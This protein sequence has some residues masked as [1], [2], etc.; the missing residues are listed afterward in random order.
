MLGIPILAAVLQTILFAGSIYV[1]VH[2]WVMPSGNFISSSSGQAKLNAK[3][4]NVLVSLVG[5]AISA[6]AGLALAI[7]AKCFIARSLASNGISLEAYETLRKIGESRLPSRASVYALAPVVLFL[8]SNSAAPAVISIWQA[9]SSHVDLTIETN[10]TSFAAMYDYRNATTEQ[11]S[12][13]EYDSLV[14]RFTDGIGAMLS[15]GGYSVGD[16]DVD[17]TS[18]YYLMEG[19]SAV[20]KSESTTVT[21]TVPFVVAQSNC[22]APTSLL[23]TNLTSTVDDVR[24][25][26]EDRLHC[27]GSAWD[28]VYSK[29]GIVSNMVHCYQNGTSYAGYFFINATSPTPTF[30]PIASCITTVA[31]GTKSGVSYSDNDPGWSLEESSVFHTHSPS[32]ADLIKELKYPA[33]ATELSHNLAA[34]QWSDQSLGG[35]G[36]VTLNKLVGGLVDQHFFEE[37]RNAS[38]DAKMSTVFASLTRA[39]AAMAVSKQV[40]AETWATL[41]ASEDVNSISLAG[42]APSSPPS[43]I[44]TPAFMTCSCLKVG[45]TGWGLLYLGVVAAMWLAVLLALVVSLRN[46]PV[47]LDPLDP[48]SPSSSPDK[49]PY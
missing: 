36:S 16:E 49:I 13:W 44:V 45:P 31:A 10:F 17:G 20:D 15:S 4:Y 22:T 39:L 43:G 38:A 32:S 40:Y 19:L 25:R 46:P 29:L 18:D 9:G 35:R 7:G 14:Y 8:I 42:T 41:S 26:V 48:V 2:P 5:A 47:S 6:V 37:P 30:T 12:P 27:P 21:L 24:V 34:Q 28:L 11:S 1:A 23:A 3:E 33:D